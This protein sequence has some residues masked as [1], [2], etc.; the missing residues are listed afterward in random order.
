MKIFRGFQVL[1]FKYRAKSKTRK[2]RKWTF[3]LLKPHHKVNLFFLLGHF[4]VIFQILSFIY[5]QTFKQ[6]KTSRDFRVFDFGYGVKSEIRKPRKLE[7]FLIKTHRNVI[8]SFFLG[9]FQFL[10][11][12]FHILPKNEVKKKLQCVK[13]SVLISNT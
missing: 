3:F 2:P 13:L 6:K 7:F 4:S 9:T 11:L 1:N 10:D 8:V 5:Y 12:L